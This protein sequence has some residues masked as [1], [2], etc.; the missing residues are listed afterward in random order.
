MPVL[1]HLH[2]QINVQEH[3][4]RHLPSDRIS[5][6]FAETWSKVREVLGLLK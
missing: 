6:Q 5:E 2:E 4:S 3:V 1:G